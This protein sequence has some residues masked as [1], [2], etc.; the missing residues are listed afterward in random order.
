MK[1]RAALVLAALLFAGCE[2]RQQPVYFSDAEIRALAA[3]RLVRAVPA[4]PSNAVLDDPAAVALGRR[5]FN[6]TR[7]SASGS[8]ACATC[9]PPATAYTSGKVVATS[10]T[11]FRKVPTLYN[12]AFNR[13]Y[14]WDGHVDSL[15]MQVLAVFANTRE[16]AATPASISGFARSDP[17]LGAALEKIFGRGGNADADQ[18]LEVDVAKAIAAYVATLRTGDTPFD[19]FADFLVSGRP[20]QPAPI[21]V[22]A[23]RGAKIFVGKGQCDLCHRGPLFTDGEFHNLGLARGNGTGPPE[24]GRAA[25]VARLLDS[26]FNLLGAYS[27]A[28]DPRVA[29]KTR[30]SR[31]AALKWGAF[32]TPGL[33]NVAATPPYMHDGRFASLPDVLNHYTRVRRL[34]RGNPQMDSLLAHV[35]VSPDETADLAAFLRTLT[36]TPAN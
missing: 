24:A 1:P 34:L 10:D 17:E 13:W 5:L 36:A 25:G 32:R 3:H 29:D 12:A 21:S 20:G 7:L 2:G 22:A 19:R 27:D 18:R 6:E 11:T 35:A 31:G 16:F 23:Q 33:R 14:T 30:Y 8:M 4:D 28:R 26:P 15:W 9:H